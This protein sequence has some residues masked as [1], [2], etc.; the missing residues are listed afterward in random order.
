MNVA[1]KMKK[2]LVTGY[3]NCFV[4]ALVQ[5]P[6]PFIFFIEINGVSGTY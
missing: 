2:L 6:N 1:G 5:S 3:K 4:D